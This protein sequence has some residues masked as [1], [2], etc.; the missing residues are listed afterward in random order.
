MPRRSKSEELLNFEISFY[1]KL[2]QAY[3]DFVDVLIP[4]GN[5][6]T[7]RGRYDKGLEIDLRLTQVRGDDPLTWYNLACSYSLLKR[8]EESVE[9][10]RRSFE[11][12]YA[13]MNY[14]QK[15]PDLLHIRQSPRYREFLESVAST[16]AA[17]REKTDQASSQSS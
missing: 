16:A 8:V 6:Y 9:A 1:E 14:M 12:G 2:L 4:L 5:A 15:D 7:R 13:D 3:P 10:L 17:T 11:L